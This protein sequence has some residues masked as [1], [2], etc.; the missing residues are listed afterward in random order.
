MNAIEAASEAR[1][2]LETWTDGEGRKRT[3][4]KLAATLLQPMAQISHRKPAKARGKASG[5][6][7]GRS[8]ASVYRP[9]KNRST[10]AAQQAPRGDGGRGFDAEIPF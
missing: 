8:P 4:L 9:L 6:D 2:K 7:G 1:L 5:K 3:G 10:G